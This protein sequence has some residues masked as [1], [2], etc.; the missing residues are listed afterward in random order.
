MKQWITKIPGRVWLVAGLLLV[1]AFWLY[2]HDAR[3]RRQARLQQMQQQTSAQVAVLKEQAEQDAEQANVK[4]AQAIRNLEAR[5]RQIEQQNQQLVAQLAALRQ[6]EQV[7]V[8][9]VATLP[10]SEIAARVATQLGLQAADVVNGS[11][12]TGFRA[13]G[14]S[15]GIGQSA[16][17]VPPG[18][19]TAASRQGAKAQ[20][21]NATSGGED[22]AATRAVVG[23]ST[24]TNPRHETDAVA[25]NSRQG[26]K[27]QSTNA[28]SGGEDTAAT[29]AVAMAL[30]GSGAR[31]VEAA[32]VELNACRAEST[33]QNQQVT[34]CQ[35]R[36]ATDGATIQRQASS[37]ASLNQA[38]Q[39]KDR[40]LNQQETE[41]K[42]ELRAAKGTFWG[43][44]ARAAKHV[45]IGVAVGVAIGV[46]AR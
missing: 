16:T 32:L 6:Q 33:V 26:A 28:T 12:G 9:E 24:Q 41:Y 29:R 46:A 13:V 5:R 11:H 2:Q 45:A 38:L 7:Q 25:T 31:K 17:S 4:N 40:I 18:K 22:T 30:T 10:I 1:A 8:G 21:I 42:A 15:E 27:A 3:I 44:V 14:S 35:A 37:I 19:E 36:A 23:I 43:R 39:A 34:N 20:S